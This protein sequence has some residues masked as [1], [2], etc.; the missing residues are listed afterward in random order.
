LRTSR[1]S[2]SARYRSTEKRSRSERNTSFFLEDSFGLILRTRETAASGRPVS[3]IA[4]KRVMT[5]SSPQRPPTY[6]Q[7]AWP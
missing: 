5:V 1:V 2:R 4:L 6:A 3:T 7:K